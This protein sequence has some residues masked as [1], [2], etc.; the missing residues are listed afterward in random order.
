MHFE[1]TSVYIM[2]KAVRLV[3]DELQSFDAWAEYIFLLIGEK[4]AH[5]P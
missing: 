4:F 3:A 2:I 5:Y 1:E